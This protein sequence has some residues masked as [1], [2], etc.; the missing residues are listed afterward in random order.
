MPRIWEDLNSEMRARSVRVVEDDGEEVFLAGGIDDSQCVTLQLDSGNYLQFQVDTGEQCNVVS[1]V[2]TVLDAQHG[3][4]HIA[5]DEASSYLTTSNTPFG[6][7]RWKRMPLG[8]KSAT[9]VF[10]RRKHEV[11]EGLQGVEVVMDDFVV[12]GCGNA[13]E[14][15][16]DHDRNLDAVLQVQHVLGQENKNVPMKM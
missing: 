14:A 11:V 16:Q 8:I 13:D 7:C 10:Q 9:E 2:F 15:T 3:F 5:L 4:W 12:V 6:R 1:K